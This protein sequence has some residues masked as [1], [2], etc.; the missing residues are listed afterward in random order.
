MVKLGYSPAYAA[1]VT[2][3]SSIIGP[4]I[5]PSLIV[6]I[7]GAATGVSIGALFA[8]CIIP[9]LLIGLLQASLVFWQSTR[10]NFPIVKMERTVKKLFIIGK[11][12]AV[13]L[14]VPLIILVG[15]MGGFITPTEAGAAA[16]AYALLAAVI[17]YRN[18]SLR[19]LFNVF[20][21]TAR[22]SSKLLIII[23]CGAVF[24]WVIA[25]EKVPETLQI[26]I[27]GARLEK[28]TILLVI[29]LLLLF[30]G[31][32]LDPAAAIILFAPL[33][34]EIAKGVGVDPVHLGVII[35]L[36]LN[37]GLLTP[38]LGI[39][40][41]ASEDIA[42]CGLPSLVNETLPFLVIGLIC[43]VLVTFFPEIS[44]WLPSILGY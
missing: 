20:I 36:N 27:S 22:V 2:S 18:L 39:C 29:N 21:N 37:I 17:I 43:L 8:A 9:G 24:S 40:L 44:L 10:R 15:I 33:L 5:P 23:G 30:I 34:N 14:M 6:V 7:Y 26:M 1:A 38:P 42:K 35:I 19:K 31:M 16:S 28:S 32:F 11:N 41:Y 3:S 4:M 25:I 13:P 12:A